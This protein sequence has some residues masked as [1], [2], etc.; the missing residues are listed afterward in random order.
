MIMLILRLAVERGE[1]A[2]EHPLSL[3]PWIFN[4]DSLNTSAVAEFVA[5]TRA[6]R[7]HPTIPTTQQGSLDLSTT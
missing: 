1:I 6:R 5:R 4:R 7:A 2:A 3:G